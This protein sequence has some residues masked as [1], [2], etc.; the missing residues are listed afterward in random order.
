MSKKKVQHQHH[1]SASEI[2]KQ[3]VRVGG[4][5]DSKQ[6]K[7]FLMGFFLVIIALVVILYFVFV[8]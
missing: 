1:L 6:M 5:D 3:H 4:G 7:N 2:Q 8:K